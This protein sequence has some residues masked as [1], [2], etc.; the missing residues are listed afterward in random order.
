MSAITSLTPNGIKTLCSVSSPVT[1]L[2]DQYF[3]FQITEM[4]V[5]KPEENKKNIKAR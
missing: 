5:F 4:K 2:V 3:V 1:E